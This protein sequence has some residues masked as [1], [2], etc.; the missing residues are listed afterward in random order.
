MNNEIDPM[1]QPVRKLVGRRRDPKEVL[2]R[3][4]HLQLFARRLT[5]DRE[6]IRERDYFPVRKVVGGSGHIRR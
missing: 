4:Y 1:Q 6:L 5:Q 2:T 3:L